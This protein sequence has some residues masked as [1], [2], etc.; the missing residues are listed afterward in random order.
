MTCYTR[1]L[2]DIFDEA[3][4]EFTKE[5]RRQADKLFKKLLGKSDC[6]ETW[7]ELKNRLV[8]PLKR[9]EVVENLKNLKKP[10]NKA[11]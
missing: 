9:G 11:S 10:P 1:H 7:R 8:D 6:P 5:N 3:G 4:V 2:K